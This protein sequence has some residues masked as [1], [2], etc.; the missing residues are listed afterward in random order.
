VD[1]LRQA[2]GNYASQQANHTQLA[3][4]CLISVPSLSI[5]RI[6]CS[7]FATCHWCLEMA[8]C[9]RAASA[10]FFLL[11]FPDVSLSMSASAASICTPNRSM[12]PCSTYMWVRVR[13][14][15]RET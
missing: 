11:F 4:Q 14:W 8:C 6:I 10:S 7:I 13:V 9:L 5:M 1:C 2:R 3:I 15:K 12:Y